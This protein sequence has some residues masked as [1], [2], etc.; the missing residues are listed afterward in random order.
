[1]LLALAAPYVLWLALAYDWH[2]LD[3]VNLVFH[4]AGHVF[5]GLLG[6]TL[7]MLGGTLGQLLVPALVVAHLAR[8]GR[9]VEAR[10]AA[11]WL[12][13][14]LLNVARY[15]GDAQAMALPLVGGEIHDW[16]WMLSRLGLLDRCT[17]LARLVQ[18]LGVTVAIGAWVA[19]WRA[20]RVRDEGAPGA[21]HPPAQRAAGPLRRSP[22]AARS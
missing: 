20:A 1:V 17:T 2:L 19:A 11:I 5:F 6:P 12:G 7:G 22:P 10:L 9:A 21:E 13:A 3:G 16:N 14:S 18:L 15:L 4:E 8:E